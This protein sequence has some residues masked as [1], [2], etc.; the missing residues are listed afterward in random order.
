MK[1][2]IIDGMLHGTGIRDK[3][4][5]G[6]LAPLDIGL[7]EAITLKINHWL[8]EYEE[9]HYNGFSNKRNTERLDYKGIEI[10]RKIRDEL[11]EL[12]V[13][14]YSNAELKELEL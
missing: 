10:A 11:S 8:L 1:E 4:E 13:F 2:I 3:L 12:R 9:E 6:Y 7:P 5:G 14:Y